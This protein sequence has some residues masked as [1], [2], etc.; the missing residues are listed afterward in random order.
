MLLL[1]LSDPD[2]LAL[3]HHR[4]DAHAKRLEQVVPTL[5]TPRIARHALGIVRV[6]M[7]EIRVGLDQFDPP[8]PHDAC[9]HTILNNKPTRTNQEHLSMSIGINISM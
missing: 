8:S 4:F 3:L 2:D 5:V 7:K 9:H 6:G 1:D